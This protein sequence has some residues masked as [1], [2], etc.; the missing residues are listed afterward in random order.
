MMRFVALLYV[1]FVSLRFI[2]LFLYYFQFYLT[3][4]VLCFFLLSLPHFFLSLSLSLHS[5]RRYATQFMCGL[6]TRNHYARVHPGKQ[7]TY[8]KDLFFSLFL[9][10][11]HV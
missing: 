10:N 4:I 1:F 11:L 5:T 8:Y 9:S 7:I 3:E 2:F 6:T